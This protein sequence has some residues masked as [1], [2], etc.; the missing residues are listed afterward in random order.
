MDIKIIDHSDDVK[1]EL[2]RKMTLALSKI[3][4]RAEDHAKALAPV[5][6]PQ[7]TGIKGYVGGRLRASITHL[8]DDRSVTIGTNVEY[9]KYQELGT[10]KME[11]QPFLWPA[12][13]NNIDEYKDILRNELE[14]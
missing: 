12:I 1:A 2:N 9:G 11:A 13:V 14:G 10:S 3:G 8:V 7:S 4:F 5:G 6:T